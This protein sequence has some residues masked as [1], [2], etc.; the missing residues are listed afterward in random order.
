MHLVKRLDEMADHVK[1]AARALILLL[2]A[3]VVREMWEHFAETTK[4]LVSCATTLHEAIDKLGTNPPEAMEL[5]KQIDEYESIVDEKYLIGKEL[6]LKHSNKM[7][8]ATIL[9]LKDIIEE[10]EHI[11]DAC[12]HVADYIRILTVARE[13]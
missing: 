2:G 13:T 11:A 1:D 4:V 5:A 7:D 12:D 9:L 10:M 8:V 6:L 3:K